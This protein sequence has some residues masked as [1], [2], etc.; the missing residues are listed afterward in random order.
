MPSKMAAHLRTGSPL[1]AGE[2]AGFEPRTAVSQ[3]GVATNEPPL[4]LK[5][6]YIYIY[7]FNHIEHFTGKDLMDLLLA[8]LS[9]R[10][11]HESVNKQP[12]F[13]TAGLLLSLF[14]T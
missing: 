6:S 9:V 13:S 1:Y 12:N 5:A 3:S 10:N 7:I 8:N 2:I 4:L 11:R 14:L